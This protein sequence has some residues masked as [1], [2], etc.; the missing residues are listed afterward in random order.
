MGRHTYTRGTALAHFLDAHGL[1]A[2]N[3]S[4]AHSARHPTSW[5]G[6]RRDA[7]TDILVKIY[8]VI[9]YIVC[10][11]PQKVLLRDSR[12]YFGTTL[13]SDHRLVDARIDASRLFSCWVGQHGQAMPLTVL[14]T[15]RSLSSSSS[16]CRSHSDKDCFH[17]T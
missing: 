9:D 12:S 4:F 14:L 11:Q 2:C 10:R 6:A 8:N 17:I 1:F 7:A 13:E 15:Q 16:C 3:T 5:Q